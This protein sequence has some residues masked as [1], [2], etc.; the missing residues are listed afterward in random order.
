MPRIGGNGRRGQDIRKPALRTKVIVVASTKGGVG[1]TTVAACLAVRAANDSPRVAMIDM[2]PQGSLAQWWIRRGMSVNPRIIADAEHHVREEV[3]QLSR[4]G[5]DYIFIDSPPAMIDVIERAFMCASFVVVPVKASS[6]DIL[7]VDAII[8][9]CR[10]HRV[11]YGLVINDAELRW[12]ITAGAIEALADA[13]PLLATIL[14]RSVYVS[15]MTVGKTGPESSDAKQAAE[16]ADEIDDLWL[17]IM[18]QMDG[19][20]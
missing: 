4:Q 6:L 10:Y 17:Q 16:A 9:L 18:A 13:G 20:K 3:D 12:K 14:H 7:A 5:W 19:S 1:K 8:D 2:D 15:A 11:T